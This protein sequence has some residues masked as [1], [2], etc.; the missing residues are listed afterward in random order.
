[1]DSGGKHLHGAAKPVFTVDVCIVHGGEFLMFKRSATK[2]IFPGW[3]A[4]PGGHIDE[5]ENPLAAA[6]REVREEV[7]IILTPKDIQLK[8]V[9]THYHTDRDEVFIVFGFRAVIHS[10]PDTLASS[11][12]GG[13]VW[14]T[15]GEL[16]RTDTI[17]PPVQYYF[18]HLSGNAPGIMYNY[19]IWNNAQLVRVVSEDTDSNS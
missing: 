11:H 17:F 5:G 6:I 12:E 7:G 18:D 14:M 15:R 10:K 4:F 19:S 1:M 13:A 16:D 9:A 8:F 3:L 2:K